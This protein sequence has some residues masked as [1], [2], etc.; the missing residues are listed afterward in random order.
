MADYFRDDHSKDNT[1]MTSAISHQHQQ[2]I[3]DQII[4]EK[5][6]QSEIIDSNLKDEELPNDIKAQLVDRLEQ[7]I[8]GNIDVNFLFHKGERLRFGLIDQHRLYKI[9]LKIKEVAQKQIY[10][11]GSK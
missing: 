5:E 10:E 6:E 11:Q 8:L 1:A 9:M 3:A 2:A 4:T 7:E